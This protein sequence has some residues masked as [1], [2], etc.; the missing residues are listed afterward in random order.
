MKNAGP[1]V[2]KLG[3]LSWQ[4]KILRK[5]RK[6]NKKKENRKR[7]S[8]WALNQVS[9][10]YGS[11]VNIR[12][13]PIKLVQ[14]MG[15]L[16]LIWKTVPLNSRLGEKGRICQAHNGYCFRWPVWRVW[17]AKNLNFL[18]PLKLNKKYGDRIWQK[19]GF[20]PQLAEGR[21]QLAGASRAGPLLPWGVQV[22]I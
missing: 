21:T 7:I 4:K 2:Q 14:R 20:H 17:S 9:C 3:I 19:G 22:L 16:Y 15:L 8:R 13:R 18:C 10:T 11:S 1:L 6:N 12:H 5:S